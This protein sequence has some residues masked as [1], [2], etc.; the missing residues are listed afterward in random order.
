[1]E[2]SLTE[3]LMEQNLL[4]K[5]RKAYFDRNCDEYGKFK[6]QDKV[7]TLARIVRANYDLHAF[8]AEYKEDFEG[9]HTLNSLEE[10]LK[11]YVGFIN[12]GKVTDPA[13]YVKLKTANETEIIDALVNAIEEKVLPEF[14]F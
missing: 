4:P 14:L 10:T 3:Q 11:G 2:T 9:K 13:T 7:D 5:A 6:M 8:I 1:M 12:G